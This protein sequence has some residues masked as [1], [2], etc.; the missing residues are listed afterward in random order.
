M[1]PKK[2][3]MTP[4]E[5]AKLLETS[6]R[7]S[8][9]KALEL[10]VAFSFGNV[11]NMDDPVASPALN[12]D[13]MIGALLSHCKYIFEYLG[14]LQGLEPSEVC[15]GYSYYFY[16]NVLPEMEAMFKSVDMDKLN[17]KIKEHEDDSSE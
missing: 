3:E 8:Y 14:D 15:Q 10:I 1:T 11:D 5:A 9:F 6:M 4:Q 12:H 16:G 2:S 7:E 13:L 17:R